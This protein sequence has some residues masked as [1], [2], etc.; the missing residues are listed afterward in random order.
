MIYLYT[1][2]FNRT[3]GKSNSYITSNFIRT[4]IATDIN[5]ET[6]ELAYIYVGY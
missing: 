1:K 5:L 4:N 2:S 6:N 3:L